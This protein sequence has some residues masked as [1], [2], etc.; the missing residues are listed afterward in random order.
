MDD[1][2]KQQRTY[3]VYLTENEGKFITQSLQGKWE[4]YEKIK[5]DCDENL[6]EL[7]KHLVEETL[8]PI[9]L[10]VNDCKDYLRNILESTEPDFQE[11]DREF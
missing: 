8:Q 3:K 2:N 9:I 4:F 11:D 1:T 5:E 10:E 7:I 6:S